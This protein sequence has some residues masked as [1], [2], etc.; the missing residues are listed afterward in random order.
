MPLIEPDTSGM[1][2]CPVVIPEV[3]GELGL[4]FCAK[5]NNSYPNPFVQYI[6]LS[7]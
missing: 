2:L 1:P 4:E 5:Y 3:K 6:R 7:E